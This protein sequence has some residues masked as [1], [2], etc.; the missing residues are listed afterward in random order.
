MCQEQMLIHVHLLF[1]VV[2]FHLFGLP[3]TWK[4][5]PAV[6]CTRL[7]TAHDAAP[8]CFG[9]THTVRAGNVMWLWPHRHACHTIWWPCA[10]PAENETAWA[11]PF[12]ASE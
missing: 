2:R 4:L 7:C 9:R 6:P 3:V 5:H 11:S 12:T 1:A 8:I 10:G